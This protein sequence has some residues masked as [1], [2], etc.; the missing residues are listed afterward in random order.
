MIVD[1]DSDD[2]KLCHFISQNKN[3]IWIESNECDFDGINIH[4]NDKHNSK[5]PT[6]TFGADKKECSKRLLVACLWVI[7]EL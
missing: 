7:F 6:P 5:K 2:H 3:F 1:N 4:N